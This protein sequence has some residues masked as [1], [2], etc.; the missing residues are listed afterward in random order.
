MSEGLS[1][2][3]VGKELHEHTEKSQGADRHSRMVQIGAQ[4]AVRSLR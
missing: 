1:P 3:E 4:G 2:V